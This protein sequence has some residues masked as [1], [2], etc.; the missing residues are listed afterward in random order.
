MVGLK[1]RTL[2]KRLDVKKRHKDSDKVKWV[3]YDEIENPYN[4]YWMPNLFLSAECLN[5]D[6]IYDIYNRSIKANDWKDHNLTN[7][8]VNIRRIIERDKAWK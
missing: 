4:Y 5:S 2:F 8:L 1:L 7:G 6:F 3:V